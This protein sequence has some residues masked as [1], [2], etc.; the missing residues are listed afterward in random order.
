LLHLWGVAEQGSA[1]VLLKQRFVDVQAMAKVAWD[2]PIVPSLEN[3]CQHIE[4]LARMEG[5]T[6][7]FEKDASPYLLSHACMDAAAAR[8]IYHVLSGSLAFSSNLFQTF[9]KHK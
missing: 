2:L 6:Q 4:C 3:M 9:E 7:V 5:V 1:S 8:W